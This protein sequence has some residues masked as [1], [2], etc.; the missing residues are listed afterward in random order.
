MKINNFNL[1]ICLIF[2]ISFSSLSSQTKREFEEKISTLEAESKI[3]KQNLASKKQELQLLNIKTLEY[4]KKYNKLNAD[5]QLL[6]NKSES[7][8]NLN[9]QKTTPLSE[10]DS[11]NVLIQNF[12]YSKNISDRKI[13]LDDPKNLLNYMEF[14][15]SYKITPDQITIIGEN[16]KIGDSFKVLIERRTLYLLKKTDGFKIDWLSSTGYNEIPLSVFKADNDLNKGYF[17]I[18]A[19]LGD[20]YNYSYRS[21]SKDF[22]NVQIKENDGDHIGS[23]YVAKTSLAGKKLYEILKDGKEH[24]LIVEIKK[25]TNDKN[26]VV[27][28]KLISNTWY[29]N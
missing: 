1:T 24:D 7:S 6:Q 9:S 25:V 17:R 15:G 12:F 28:E 18:I 19:K 4:E 16:F 5:Y 29:R 20:Y 27:I 11:I 23:C 13:F 8:K 2:S 22:W 14:H 3:C 21:S 26:S 10:R